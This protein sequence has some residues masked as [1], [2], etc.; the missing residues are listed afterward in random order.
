VAI[1]DDDPGVRGSI[2]SLVRSAG[3]VGEQFSDGLALL[4][5][6]DLEAIDCIVTDLHMPGM[7]GRALRS[8]PRPHA[9]RCWRAGLAPF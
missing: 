1:V 2:A 9:T 6:G 3:M 5:S 7:D 8:R 4:A